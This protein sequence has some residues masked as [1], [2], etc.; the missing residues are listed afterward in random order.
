MN[1]KRRAGDRQHGFCIHI[2]FSIITSKPRSVLIAL[3]RVGGMCC[4]GLPWEVGRSWW[5]ET[6]PRDLQPARRRAAAGAVAMGGDGEAVPASLQTHGP[7]P[8]PPARW[9]TVADRANGGSSRR[10]EGR[11]GCYILEAFTGTCH[12]SPAGGDGLG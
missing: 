7:S 8:S 4:R 11:L 9:N 10:A 12:R 5:G 1:G 6:S 3:H 2:W